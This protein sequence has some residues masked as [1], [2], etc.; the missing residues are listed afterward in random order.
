MLSIEEELY[1]INRTGDTV[2]VRFDKITDRNEHLL[3][4]AYGSQLRHVKKLLTGITREVIK[5]FRNGMSTHDLDMLTAAVCTERSSHHPD[6][7]NLAA[8]ILVSDLHKT[9]PD[10]YAEAVEIIAKANP[11]RLNP[12]LVELARRSGEA[13]E[14]RIDYTR[15]Y[16][17]NSFGFHSVER[18]LFREL[19]ADSRV[20]ER[21]QHMYMRVA[22]Q[23]RVLY[24]L[25]VQNRTIADL[26]DAELGVYLEEA[27]VSYDLS[28]KF[29]ISHATPTKLN[30]GTNTPQLASCFL[31]TVADSM[32]ALTTIVSQTTKIS[33]SAGG[34]GVC[35][36]PM[37]AE[38]SLIKSNGGESTGIRYYLNL[39]NAAKDYAN[40]GNFRKGAFA[41]YLAPWHADIFTFIEMGRFTGFT[42][43]INAPKLKYGLWISDLFMRTTIA[44]LVA[45]SEGGDA[46]PTAGDW[47]LFSPDEAPGLY[48]CHGEKFEA[49][50]ARYVQEKRYRRIVK[51]SEI[52]SE[53]FRTVAQRGSPYIL[54]GDNVNHKSNL[55]HVATARMSNLCVSGTTLVLTSKGQLPIADLCDREVEVWNGREWSEVTVRQTSEQSALVEVTV[56]NGAVLEC[57]P[58][59]KFYN[60]SGKE[61]RAAEL[62][63]GTK[64]EKAQAWPVVEGGSEFPHAYTHGFFCADGHYSTP[65]GKHPHRCKYKVPLDVLL[66]GKHKTSAPVHTDG[67]EE[68]CCANVGYIAAHLYGPK[69]DLLGRLELHPHTPGLY[70]TESLERTTVHFPDDLLPKYVVP[71]GASLDCRLR[72]FEGYCDG[73][74][75]VARNKTTYAIQAASTHPEFL[76]N[77]RLML[78]TMGCDPKITLAQ[79][80]RT[81]SIRG[82]PEFKSRALYRLLLTSVDLWRLI[83]LGFAP[84]RLSFEGAERPKRDARRFSTIVKVE[85]VDEEKPTFCFTEP[86][87]HRGV[88]GG[89]LTGQCTEITIPSIFD[90][91]KPDEQE[92]GTCILGATPLARYVLPD[93]SSP[94]GVRFDWAGLITASKALT[95][96]LDNLTEVSHYTVEACRRSA[97]RHRPLAIGVIG[98]SDVLNMFRYPFGSPEALAL[99]RA[100]HAAVYY[101]AMVRSAELGVERG[102]FP[103]YEGSATQKGIL[104]PD[105]WT[106]RGHLGAGWEAEI[107][108]TTGG[109]IPAGAWDELRGAV[110]RGLR[111]AF[112]TASMPTASTSNLVDQ[113]PGA[114]PCTQNLGTQNTLAGEGTHLNKYLH[115]ELENLEMWDEEMRRALIANAGSCQSIARIPPEVRALYKT[116]RELDQKLVVQHAAAGGPF[117][118]QSKSVNVSYPK[119]T[120]PT[121]LD[122]LVYSWLLGNTTGSYYTHSS[123][124][125]GTA[126]ASSAGKTSASSDG[127]KPLVFDFNEGLCDSCGV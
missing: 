117:I 112:V 66:C 77:V 80:A 87:R 31:L 86:T 43:D 11:R 65:D 40:Q 45:N 30:A 33:A 99:D 22:L 53:W 67:P 26:S 36:T 79:A 2:P 9:T 107:E 64:L 84:F 51:A 124:A 5:R 46:D 18:Y 110:K 95:E 78:Q 126:L 35:L 39:L 44:E 122:I 121:C 98:L 115:R 50:H 14:R 32:T 102:N 21:P 61:I 88:F 106:A 74:G 54:F 4:S 19:G 41:A 92:I 101:G 93:A 70:K 15:D 119:P 96:N 89:I 116:A 52:W 94:R 111:N 6:Y 58:A 68:G 60:S 91:D 17:F 49:L 20:V 57:T 25:T 56:S 12:Q 76:N 47:H 69:R 85:P 114:E 104:Q 28:S 125:S 63:P 29:L 10:R 3:G 55:A 27:F 72:W 100:I 113:T 81:T 123:P 59:H 103:S 42:G 71:L 109:A 48:E 62:V 118:S 8:R 24:Q 97:L 37:R 105:M 13:I 16:M 73:D 1:V 82:E 34:V 23:L 108:A 75:C 127:T 120:L 7:G 83:D 38:G 90:E